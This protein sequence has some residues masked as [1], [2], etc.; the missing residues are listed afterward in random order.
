MSEQPWAC[1]AGKWNVVRDEKFEEY[2]TDRDVNFILKKIVAN[3]KPTFDIAVDGDKVTVSMS[4]GPKTVGPNTFVVN[5]ADLT[6]AEAMDVK[7]KVKTTWEDGK[8][9]MDM[10]PAEEGKGKAQCVYREIVGEEM[11]MTMV[12]GDVV[13][14]RYLQKA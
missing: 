4:L 5:G 2:L 1:M 8:L 13:C 12:S 3:V 9:K 6:E 10:V 14:K 11:V 7:M